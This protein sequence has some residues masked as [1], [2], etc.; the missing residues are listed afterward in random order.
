MIWFLS[1][2]LEAVVKGATEPVVMG[3]GVVNVVMAVVGGAAS[4]FVNLTLQFHETDFL[5]MRSFKPVLMLLHY[6]VIVSNTLFKESQI[7]GLVLC[8][9]LSL[10]TIVQR[11]KDYEY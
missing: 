9:G 7:V 4:V 8:L 2:S 3:L 10:L 11:W 1:V 5:A 6:G